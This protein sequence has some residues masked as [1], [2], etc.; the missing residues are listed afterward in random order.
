MPSESLIDHEIV[1]TFTDPFDGKRRS[2][3]EEFTYPGGSFRVPS[4]RD[5]GTGTRDAIARL[6][7]LIEP[8]GAAG[9]RIDEAAWD[10]VAARETEILARIL[11]AYGDA[12]GDP[13]GLVM[14]EPN[15]EPSVASVGRRRASLRDRDRVIVWRIVASCLLVFSVGL[16]LGVVLACSRKETRRA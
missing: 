4:I 9:G 16:A 14:V 5:A 6:L 7:A 10:L 1:V 11:A 12:T 2:W 13:L 8:L 15:T 3:E